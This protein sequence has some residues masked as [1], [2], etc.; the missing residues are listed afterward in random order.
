MSIP[1][2]WVGPRWRMKSRPN[3]RRRRSSRDISRFRTSRIRRF[4]AGEPIC[5]TQRG[6]YEGEPVPCKKP[7]STRFTMGCGLGRPNCPSISA[8]R[9]G[10]PTSRGSPCQQVA[11]VPSPS[12]ALPILRPASRM[13]VQARSSAGSVFIGNSRMKLAVCL[14]AIAQETTRRFARLQAA[15]G[16]SPFRAMRSKP[17]A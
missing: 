13:M 1:T 10:A 14:R 4:H 9:C 16:K 8:P 7:I 11:V 2:T 6:S 5:S 3:E 12:T 15:C 17:P